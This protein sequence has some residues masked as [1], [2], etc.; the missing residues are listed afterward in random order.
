MLPDPFQKECRDAFKKYGARLPRPSNPDDIPQPKAK[1][2][3]QSLRRIFTGPLSR[4]R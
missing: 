3:L 4:V 2:L 1:A